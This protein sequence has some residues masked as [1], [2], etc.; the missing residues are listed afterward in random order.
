M[1]LKCL[2][3]VEFQVLF[4]SNMEVSCADGIRHYDPCCA[5]FRFH[6]VTEEPRQ[7]HNLHWALPLL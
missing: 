5:V 4:L 7:F 6:S 2:G 3:S 1:F